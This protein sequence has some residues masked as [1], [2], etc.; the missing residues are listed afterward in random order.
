[1][2]IERQNT[3]NEI[4]ES[5]D[6]NTE[7]YVMEDFKL[8]LGSHKKI[9]NVLE[10]RD[11]I[12]KEEFTRKELEKF[13]EGVFR[14]FDPLQELV[15]TKDDKT[16]DF[17]FIK[18]IKAEY[19]DGYKMKV[20]LELYEN[21]YIDNKV[22]E[23]TMHVFEGESEVTKIVWKSEKGSCPLF[24][25]FENEDDDFESFDIFYELYID[26]LFLSNIGNDE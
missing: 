8:K 22:L 15:P 1:M 21:E 20:T 2:N 6:E 14:S 11:R 3:L 18:F 9:L 12:L 13:F 17:S 25:F 7:K 19:L 23:K 10:K 4:Q 26:L 16:K 5:I 24:D